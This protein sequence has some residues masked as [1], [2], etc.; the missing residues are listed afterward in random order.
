MLRLLVCPVRLAQ[1]HFL[2]RHLSHS[3]VGPTSL[4]EERPTRH[5][6]LKLLCHQ[7]MVLPMPQKMLGSHLLFDVIRAV[8][9]D[10]NIVYSCKFISGDFREVYGK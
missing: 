9:K 1:R 8:G 4:V 6:L 7:M 5:P 3:G 10:V 2:R